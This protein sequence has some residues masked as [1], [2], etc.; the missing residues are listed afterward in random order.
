VHFK[1][2]DEAEGLYL[3]MDRAN[4]AI[5]MR[6]RLGAP[7]LQP[8]HSLAPLPCWMVPN[9]LWREGAGRLGLGFPGQQSVIESNAR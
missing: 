4:L 5:D 7:P 8:A 9:W 6:M 3:K 1:R 2:F